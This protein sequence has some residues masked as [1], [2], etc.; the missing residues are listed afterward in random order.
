MSRYATPLSF[1]VATQY[2]GWAC[3]PLPVWAPAPCHCFLGEAGDPPCF[4]W[5]L[6]LC[7]GERDPGQI[8]LW[9]QQCQDHGERGVCSLEACM[10]SASPPLISCQFHHH[11][12][13]LGW[14]EIAASASPLPV[15]PNSCISTCRRSIWKC[16]SFHFRMCVGSWILE[17][18]LISFHFYRSSPLVL[19]F[20][21]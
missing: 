9:T 20:V 7:E 3:T 13:L 12:C 19:V 2:I 10:F 14:E 17:G 15:I 21:L 1:C 5:C 16:S 18:F 11:A 8:N 6:C 4:W